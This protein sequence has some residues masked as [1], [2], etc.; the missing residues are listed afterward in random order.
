M[1]ANLPAIGI[2]YHSITVHARRKAYQSAHSAPQVFDKSPAAAAQMQLC[3][4]AQA[5]WRDP[6]CR[7][8]CVLLFRQHRTIMSAALCGIFAPGFCPRFLA[9]HQV[10]PQ[11]R[12][13]SGRKIFS[14][15]ALAKSCGIAFI[16][17]GLPRH[18]PCRCRSLSGRR[19]APHPSGRR[20]FQPPRP[21][22]RSRRPP[23]RP[24]RPHPRG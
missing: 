4:H 3:P 11:K 6:P 8:L 20:R 2:F 15:I 23:R 17:P 10:L 7:F 19:S 18:H 14:Q 21:R 12:A 13:A 24:C 1:G 9:I 16:F 5:A 22:R